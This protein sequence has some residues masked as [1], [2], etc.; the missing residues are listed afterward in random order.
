MKMVASVEALAASTQALIADMEALAANV[1]ALTANSTKFR[2]QMDQLPWV[3]VN[4]R[5]GD[6]GTLHNPTSIFPLTEPNPRN[7]EELLKFTG[8]SQAVS[9]SNA[10]PFLI[11]P[12]DAVSQCIASAKSLGLPSLPQD[13]PVHERRRQIAIRLGVII[14]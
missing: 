3:R 13:T 12:V 10:T 4:S 14:E 6:W 5:P 11:M 8:E 2:R 9:K 1:E 7:S